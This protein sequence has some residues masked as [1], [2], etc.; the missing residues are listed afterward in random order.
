[1]KLNESQLRSADFFTG[2]SLVLAGPGSGKTAVIT[3][4]VK[5]LIEKYHVSADKILVASFSR[6]AAEEMEERFSKLLRLYGPGPVFGTF[7]SIFYSILKK[8]GGYDANR[9]LSESQKVEI[10]R[11]EMV[12]LQIDFEASSDLYRSILNDISRIKSGQN[13]NGFFMPLSLPPAAFYPVCKAYLQ[14]TKDMGVLDFDDI[15]LKCY[16]L[17]K[18]RPDLLEYCRKR[19]PFILIDEFQ[20]INPVQYEIIRLIAQPLNNIFAVGDDDQSIYGFRGA[21][22]QI[23][24]RF[25][26]DFPNAVVNVLNMNYRS[27]PP[28]VNAA[29]VV[30]RGNKDRFEKQV[31]C[32]NTSYS[33]SSFVLKSFIDSKEESSA[34]I[35]EIKAYRAKGGPLSEIAILFRNRLDGNRLARR[36]AK[37]KIPVRFQGKRDTLFSSFLTQDLIAYMKCAKALATEVKTRRN[38]DVPVGSVPLVS[39]VSP[40]KNSSE[41][42]RSS[43]LR[44][45]NKPSRY[46]S[47]NAL[48]ETSGNDSIARLFSQLSQYYSGNSDLLSRITKLKKDLH[49]L[50]KCSPYAAITYILKAVGYLSYLKEYAKI[51]QIPFEELEEELEELLESCKGLSSL[52]EWL[53]IIQ[54][55][56]EANASSSKSNPEGSED[57]DAVQIMT[58]HA[59]KGLEF[60]IVYLPDL[61]QDVIP[62]KKA[63]SKEAIAEERRILY[64]AMTRARKSL[65]MGYTEIIR[66]KKAAP[67]EFLDCFFH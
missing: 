31:F 56:E 24:K 27:C 21:S 44:I 46:I 2:P 53:E 3:Y 19:F 25:L 26:Q 30:I 4:R 39:G 37:E 58:M 67:S 57:I 16:A 34:M 49:F 43:L 5:N 13:F 45:L 1:M 52:E 20:D 55:S 18:A 14:T 8:G 15:L 62:G 7:H 9:I 51:H 10:I 38:R 47:R 11:S 29:T 50:S 40:S 61:N 6:S 35:A 48:S 42:T 12:R 59:S 33:G 54:E 66:N 32:S 36:L 60:N 28:I 63:N 23:M 64:V 41:N 65:R 17:L 22:P